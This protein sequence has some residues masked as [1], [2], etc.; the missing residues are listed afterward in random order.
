MTVSVIDMMRLPYDRIKVGCLLTFQ[1]KANF[2]LIT[3]FTE[4]ICWEYV[5]DLVNFFPYCLLFTIAHG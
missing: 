5:T 3:E 4:D 1:F 2:E